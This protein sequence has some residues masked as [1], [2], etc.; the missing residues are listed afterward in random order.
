MSHRELLK[1]LMSVRVEDGHY[2]MKGDAPPEEEPSERESRREPMQ[3]A[4]PERVQHPV[5]AKRDVGS[6]VGGLASR[7]A[8]EV[9]ANMQ[10]AL[11]E[12]FKRGKK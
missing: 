1:R 10:R 9:G 2:R 3:H 11:D 7:K 4:E 8:S 6:F 5:P 12:K